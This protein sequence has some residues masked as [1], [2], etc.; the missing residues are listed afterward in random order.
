MY[1]QASRASFGR[2]SDWHAQLERHAP[3]GV[4]VVLCAN[5]CDLQPEVTAAEGRAM[6]ARF[7]WAFVQT[8]AKDDIGVDRAAA[9]LLHRCVAARVQQTGQQ[10]QQAASPHPPRASGSA[11]QRCSLQ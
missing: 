3:E 1:D 10:Q 9:L 8:S 11:E 7:G 5:K 6:A 4:Q 2:V